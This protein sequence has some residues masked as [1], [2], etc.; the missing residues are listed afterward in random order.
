MPAFYLDVT[1]KRHDVPVTAELYREA[2]EK[3]LTLGQLINTK[4]NDLDAQPNLEL[5][6]VFQQVCASTGLV[7]VGDNPF[8]RRSPM[9]ADILEGKCGYDVASNTQKRSDPYGNEARSLFP[10]AV[11]E[12]IEDRMQ[13]DRVTDNRIFRNM[14]ALNTSIGTDVFVQPVITYNVPGGGGNTGISGARASRVTE[15][16]NTPMMLTLG[17]SERTRTLPTYGIGIEASDKA[18]AG[19]TLDML[20]MTVDRYTSVEMDGRVYG[21]LSSLF[22]G[23]VDSIQGAVPVIQSSSLDPAA[24]GNKFTHK[25]W[26]KF[27]ARKRKYRHIT[28]VIAD[29]DT[30]LKWEQR[31]GRPGSNN[32]DP[33]LARIDPQGEVVNKDGFGNDVVWWIVEP[34][35]DGGPV[36]ANTI[37]ALDKKQAIMMVKNLSADYRAT[38]E[39]VLQRKS[40]MVWHWG[41]DCFRLWGDN[42]LTPFDA[43]YLSN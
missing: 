43:M 25:A 36:P 13:P 18:L 38:Q 41:E 32:Y 42:D 17:T 14:V 33:T 40:A 26:V 30:Y 8:G 23:D 6:T 4:F 39:F 20:V 35:T 22:N 7:L 37:W 3:G 19:T 16:G 28:H 31:E 11:I 29:H 10:A 2:Q 9:L 15:N 21:Y 12:M 27:L 24:V 34:A 1:G 5:G